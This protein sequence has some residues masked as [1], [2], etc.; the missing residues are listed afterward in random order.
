MSAAELRLRYRPDDEWLG[1]LDAAVTSGAFSGRGSAWF[2]REKLKDTFIAAL[3]AFPLSTNDPPLIEGGFWSKERPGALE[4]CHLRIAMRPHDSR[5]SVLVQVDLASES[6]AT[7]D[8]DRQQAVTARFLAQYA[9]IDA[10]ASQ[11][12]KVLDGTQESAV[13]SGV[14]G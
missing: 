6:W 8:K 13:L 3:R 2:N 1:E 5:G 12:E 7:P 11:L 9:A 10:F 4:Q 14:S